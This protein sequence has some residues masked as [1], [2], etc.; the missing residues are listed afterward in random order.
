MD[1]YQIDINCKFGCKG[2]EINLTQESLLEVLYE[3]VDN[4][5]FNEIL[6]AYL[7]YEFKG[8]ATIPCPVHS[9]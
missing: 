6:K 3:Y 7:K 4:P 1:N 9:L 5:K 2:G 8:E